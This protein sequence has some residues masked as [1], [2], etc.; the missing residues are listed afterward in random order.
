MNLIGVDFSINKPAVCI[1]SDNQYKFISWPYGLSQKLSDLYNAF[2]IKIVERT[3]NK[4]KGDNISAKMRYEVKNSEYLASLIYNDLLPYLNK[5]T[6]IAFEGLSYGSSGDVLI[7]LGG[8]KYMLMNKL[9]E[10]VPLENMFTYSPI[11]VKSVAGCA[12]RGM[13]KN[14]MIQAFINKGPHT[15]F[16]HELKENPINFKNK[17]GINWITHLDD[18]I[19]AYW[20]LETLKIKENL[21][22][23]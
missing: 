13:G 8:Y 7:Q 19:D 6:Y 1:F 20:V 12:K 14:E 17:K 23:I 18:I 4:E 11:T 22:S 16:N 3:D 10:I 9:S 2:G 15:I 5:D 21:T